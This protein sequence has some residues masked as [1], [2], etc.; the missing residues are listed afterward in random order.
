MSTRPYHSDHG[1][2]AWPIM[3]REGNLNPNTKAILAVKQCVE[4]RVLETVSGFALGVFDQ[5]DPGAGLKL[6]AGDTLE[7]AVQSILAVLVEGKLK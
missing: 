4:L 3:H 1:I 2:D 5:A 7:S 6:Y